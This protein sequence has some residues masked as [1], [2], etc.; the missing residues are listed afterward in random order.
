[1]LVI[2]GVLGAILGIAVATVQGGANYTINAYSG[3]MVK[4]PLAPGVDSPLWPLLFVVI[5]CGAVSGWH[6]LVSTS[7]TARQLEKETDA[8]PVGGGAMY[9][10]AVLGV[11]SLSFAA[12]TFAS[13]QAYL[14]DGLGK[15]GAP[16][17]FANG[18]AVFLNRLGVPETFGQ[19]FGS[20]FLVVMALTVMQLVLRFMR[21][22][23]AEL[24]GDR[25]PAFKNP[26]F[27]SLVA[28]GFTLLLLWTGFWNR[29]WI[30]FGG[31]NQLFAGLALLLITIWLA[32]QSKAYSWAFYPGIF[33]YITTV[34]ALL[35]T[36]WASL[37]LAFVPPAAGFAAAAWT[38]G[39][40]VSAA[41]GFFLSAAAI[42]L[43]WDG[44]QAL[45]K[46]RTSSRMRP[47]AAPAAK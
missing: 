7:G 9:A 41:I 46:A 10:E 2:L 28:I 38:F 21:V 31:S 39:N 42:V 13:H 45:N 3:F 11:L 20:V 25:M 27:G 12:A 18:M 36:G 44:M 4:G 26:H 17:V 35:Y 1:W 15:L 6:S 29:I 22:A 30:L 43:A 5:S 23:S 24:I 32:Q 34:A 16:G 8:L 19:A 33:M 37:Q 47:G 14:T 40:L